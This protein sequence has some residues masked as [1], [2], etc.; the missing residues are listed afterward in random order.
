LA[1]G[2]NL[3]MNVLFDYPITRLLNYPMLL[4]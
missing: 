3:E 1:Y 2:C 4:R